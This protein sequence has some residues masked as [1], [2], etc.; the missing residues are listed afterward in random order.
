MGMPI[1]AGPDLRAFMTATRSLASAAHVARRLRL[2]GMTAT[3]LLDGPM[4]GVAFLAY[5]EKVLLPELRE[6][7]IVVMD[8]LASHKVAG[9]RW[10]I[11]SVGR[12]T[13]TRG[14][15]TASS[16]VRNFLY[17]IPQQHDLTPEP[18]YDRPSR[19]TPAA[20]RF[21]QNSIDGPACIPGAPQRPARWRADR[22][23]A[24]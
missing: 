22:R 7:D 8:N 14:R 17:V 5:A 12:S 13:I 19:F 21:H 3:M 9:V 10:M 24:P 18:R 15:T 23:A 1:Q 11:E 20:R 2:S 4:H 16:N 6:G